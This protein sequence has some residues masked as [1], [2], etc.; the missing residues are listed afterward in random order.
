MCSLSL[1]REQPAQVARHN[2]NPGRTRM[3]DRVEHS[4]MTGRASNAGTLS[5]GPP[6]SASPWHVVAVLVAVHARPL[7]YTDVQQGAGLH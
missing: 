2:R 7:V 3:V 1:D 6:A 5:A 4:C